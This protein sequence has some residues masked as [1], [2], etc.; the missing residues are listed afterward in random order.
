M[1]AMTSVA[2]SGWPHPA[3]PAS[4]RERKKQRTRD[5]LI[6]AAFQLFGQHGFDATTVE[7]IAEAVEVSPRTFFRYFGTKEDCV[8][9]MLDDQMSAMHQA[10]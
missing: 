4:L 10:F 8:L 2:P 5:A 6:E 9:S 1:T 3:T 7:E